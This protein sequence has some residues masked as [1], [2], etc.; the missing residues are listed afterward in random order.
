[1]WLSHVCKGNEVLE[2]SSNK[3]TIIKKSEEIEGVKHSN[4]QKLTFP[5]KTSRTSD[6]TFFHMK[7]VSKTSSE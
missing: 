4:G 5:F 3:A 2:W 6:M 1:M 7:N